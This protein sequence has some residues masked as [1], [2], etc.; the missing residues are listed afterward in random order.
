PRVLR[1]DDVRIRQ[2][3]TNLL[4]NSIKYTEKGEVVLTVRLEEAG[5]PAGI[6]IS[7]KDTGIGIIEEDQKAPISTLPLNRRLW[8]KHL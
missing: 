8:T 2:I 3:V 7:V 1:G 6:M 4:T 5:N